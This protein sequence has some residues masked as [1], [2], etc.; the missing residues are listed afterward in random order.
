MPGNVI[1]RPALM[2]GRPDM[3]LGRCY[4]CPYLLHRHPPI[5][6]A[7]GGSS[8]PTLLFLEGAGGGS[9]PRSHHGLYRSLPILDLLLRLVLRDAV[10]LLDAPE[11]LV[12]MA[13]DVGQVVI[14]Q[15]APLLLHLALE[16]FPLASGAIPIHHT[17]LVRLLRQGNSGVKGWFRAE[18]SRFRAET[19]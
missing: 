8:S 16:L 6:E 18:A 7:G 4:H 14:C 3:Y 17:L 1:Q 5:P 12:A 19:I 15:L 11:K 10:A 9:K 2:P 13:V